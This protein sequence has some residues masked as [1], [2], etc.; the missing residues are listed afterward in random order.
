MHFNKGEIVINTLRSVTIKDVAAAAQVSI[1]TVSRVINHTGTVKPEL[2]DR[3]QQAIQELNYSPN[4][5]AR[6]LKTASTSTIAFLVSNIS[7]PF[8]TTIGRGI[9]DYIK[10]FGYNLIVCSID[11]SKEK[12]LSYLQMLKEK[13]VDGIILNTTG[14]NDEAICELSHQLPIVLSNRRINASVFNGDFVD[15]DN[16]SGIYQLTQHLI[17]LGHRKIG[18]INGPMHL[19]T[20]AERHKGFCDAMKSIGI[21]IDD[22]YPYAYYGNFSA[23]SGY[24]GAKKLMKAEDRPTALVLMNSELALG[25]LRYF[26]ESNIQIPEDLSIVSFGDIH[27]RE[28]LYVTPTVASTNLMGIGYKMGELLLDRIN[29]K[30]EIANREVCFVTQISYGNSTKEIPAE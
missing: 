9:E 1:A 27:N 28:L 7:D 24:D 19:S 16:T 4:S 22:S 21:T 25:A 18:F 13:M 2:A 11:S 26:A 17:H 10:D 8:F 6:S 15:N 30:N 23:Q 14:F 29:R 3:V 12:E 20:A 5:V